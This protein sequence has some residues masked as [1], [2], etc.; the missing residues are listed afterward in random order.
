MFATPAP[1]DATLTNIKQPYSSN[2]IS[3][4]NVQNASPK[5]DTTTIVKQIA[6]D[7]FH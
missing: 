1:K 6:H 5:F 7:L 2:L 4:T 3:K